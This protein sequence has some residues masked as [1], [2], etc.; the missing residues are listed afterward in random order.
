MVEANY[1]PNPAGLRPANGSVKC[2]GCS[3][4][5]MQTDNRSESNSSSSG[6]LLNFAASKTPRQVCASTMPTYSPQL[7]PC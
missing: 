1:T 6:V 3:S 5:E 2:S 4:K 7:H